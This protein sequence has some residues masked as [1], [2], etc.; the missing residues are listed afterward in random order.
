MHEAGH[1]IVAL[2]LGIILIEISNKRICS[3]RGIL[4]DA[5]CDVDLSPL[6]SDPESA[7]YKAA[8]FGYAGCA[9][10][11]QIYNEDVQYLLV[12]Q[13]DDLKFIAKYPLSDEQTKDA[14]REAQDLTAAGKQT[15]EMLA[16]VLAVKHHLTGEEVRQCLGGT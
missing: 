3:P 6:N 12:Q 8:V 13:R 4:I 11:A 2:K 7:A 14:L 10:E 16:R 15:I 9:I 1:A 5:Y